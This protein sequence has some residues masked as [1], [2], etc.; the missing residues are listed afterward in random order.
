V[1]WHGFKVQKW[2]HWH[3][4]V[5]IHR[6]IRRHTQVLRGY[7]LRQAQLNTQAVGLFCLH[8]RPAAM[9]FCDLGHNRQPQ[10][11][12]PWQGAGT[13]EALEHMRQLLL[14]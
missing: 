9:T 8:D 3:G 14:G 5:I 6:N 2:I 1:D 4:R 7:A 10:A 12:A 11:A 13:P